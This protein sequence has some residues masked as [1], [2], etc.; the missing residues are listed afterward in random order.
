MSEDSRRV[1][2]VLRFSEHS[3]AETTLVPDPVLDAIVGQLAPR[4][5]RI[6]HHDAEAFAT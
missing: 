2:S 1:L 4:L 6:Y 5:R 3:L